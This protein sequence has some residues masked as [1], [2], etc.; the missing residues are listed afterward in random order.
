MGGIKWLS[1]SSSSKAAEEKV[2]KE[3]SIIKVAG[4]I[5]CT[6]TISG[7][8][9]LTFHTAVSF[10][11]SLLAG[12]LIDIDHLLDYYLQRGFSL[13]MKNIYIWFCDKKYKF[14]FIFFHSLELILLLWVAISVFKLGML[15]V[16]F[17][18]GL[19]Q[20]IIIDIFSNRE[21]TSYAYLLSYRVIKGFK[22]KGLSR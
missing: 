3:R 11:A 18:I 5:I 12:I 2:T 20:H 7:F 13:R 8:V 14:V 6:V 22:K 16:A 15:W 21:L 9:Y 4:H 1:K 19:T 17:A 10:F